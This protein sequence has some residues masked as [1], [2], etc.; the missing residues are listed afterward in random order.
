MVHSFR[1]T[2]TSK[3]DATTCMIC[4]VV[5]L[6][7]LPQVMNMNFFFFKWIALPEYAVVLQRGGALLLQS[8]FFDLVIQ[9]GPVNIQRFG[10]T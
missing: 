3:T 8:E 4:F 2:S 7:N 5:L 9:R 1:S 10:R 6:S